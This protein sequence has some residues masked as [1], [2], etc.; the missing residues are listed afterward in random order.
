MTP[1][2]RRGGWSRHGR[3]GHFTYRDAQGRR[4]ADETANERLT[5]LAIPPAWKDVWISPS[6]RAKLQATG[7]DAA[8]RKQYLYHPAF[9]AAQEREKFE[10][11]VAF[12]NGLPALRR[13]IVEDLADGPYAFEWTAAIAITVVNR[14]WFRVGS[15]EAARSARTY[16]VT[17]LTKRHVELEGRRLTFSFRGKHRVLQRATI[18]DATLAGAMRKLTALPGGGRLFRFE[19]DGELVALRAGRL[20]DYFQERF[21]DG[22]TVKDFRTWGGTLTAAVALAESGP[23]SS[24]T[25]AKRK[26]ADAYRL[27]AE[28]LGNTPAVARSSYVSPVLVERFRQGRVLGRVRPPSKRVLSIRSTGLAPEERA[29]LR[30][31]AD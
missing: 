23:P 22:F 30:L 5:G 28:E 17:T 15:E 20:N 24:E 9:R 8:G 18:V 3:S 2:R 25:D 21:V 14:T 19:S 26:L 12:G 11:L 10:R 6:P 16:G 1:R 29:L 13:R 31:L 27:V 7:I 4:I